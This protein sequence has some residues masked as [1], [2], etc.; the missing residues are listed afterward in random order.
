M[1]YITELPYTLADMCI[2]EGGMYQRGDRCIREEIEMY[3]RENKTFRYIGE[4]CIRA[5]LCI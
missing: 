2:Y 3:Q 4:R 5:N 1:S